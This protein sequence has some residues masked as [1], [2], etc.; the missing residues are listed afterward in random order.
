MKL[1]GS[2][3]NYI[4]DFFPPD[5]PTKAK[6]MF[7]RGCRDRFVVTNQEATGRAFIFS[8]TLLK[9][10]LN[11]SLKPGISVFFRKCDAEVVAHNKN[12]IR[13][14]GKVQLYVSNVYNNIDEC[15]PDYENDVDEESSPQVKSSKRTSK[16]S[17]VKSFVYA[18]IEF[19]NDLDNFKFMRVR[20]FE[21]DRKYSY[22][23]IKA[24]DYVFMLM[25]S[26]K[27]KFGPINACE[28][29][30]KKYNLSWV[31]ID[32]GNRARKNIRTACNKLW[33]KYKS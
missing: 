29:A 11:N 4:D 17:R 22:Q 24:L 8:G 19:I 12:V 6:L 18:N 3:V 1:E 9:T 7:D 28:E 5:V 30:A 13:Y 27:Y 2:N 23:M 31:D 14:N 20:E 25:S 26:K 32:R 16:Y 33:K 15:P 10:D 21:D